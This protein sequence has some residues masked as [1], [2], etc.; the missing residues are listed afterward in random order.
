[1]CSG[2]SRYS[3]EGNVEETLPSSKVQDPSSYLEHGHHRIL[4]IEQLELLSRAS[5]RIDLPSG[6]HSQGNHH[7]RADH[8]YF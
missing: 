4:Q 8:S 7:P 5:R 6:Q 1:V 2:L 3:I